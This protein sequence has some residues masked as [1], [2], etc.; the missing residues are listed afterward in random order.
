MQRIILRIAALWMVA[1]TFSA[2]NH[3][4]SAQ[5]S[6]TKTIPGDY[7]TIG[8]AIADIQSSGLSGNVIL[9]LQQSY[10]WH[11]EFYPLT[12]P[13][14]FPTGHNATVT[15]RPA[16]G[17]TGVYVGTGFLGGGP[18]PTGDVPIFNIYGSYFILDGRPGGTGTSR[19]LYIWS[20]APE[21]SAI[22]FTNNASFNTVT[23]CNLLGIND[24]LYSGSLGNKKGIV[25]FS[26]EGPF[27]VGVLGGINNNTIENCLFDG[28]IIWKP[29]NA[30]Y[31]YGN[32][33]A[34]NVGNKILNN[35]IRNFTYAG[36]NI[37]PDGQGAGWTISGNSFY[38]NSPDYTYPEYAI[39]IFHTGNVS[40]AN[41]IEGNYIGGN[42]PQAAGKWLGGPFF[43]IVCGTYDGGDSVSVRNNVIKNMEKINPDPYPS[44]CYNCDR[45]AAISITNS[46]GSNK[47]YCTGNFIG[48]GNTDY[49]ISVSAPAT[50]GDADFYG[51]LYNNCS[52]GGITQNT[53]Q[54]ISMTSAESSTF[55]GIKAY[56]INNVTIAE[57][58]I[59]QGNIISTGDVTVSPLFISDDHHEVITCEP[60]PAQPAVFDH[61]LINSITA[62]STAGDA[63]FT[64]IEING[65]LAS[66]TGNV[67]GSATQVNSINVSGQTVSVN[68]VLVTG[69]PGDVSVS[70]DIIAN[71]T[72]NGTVSTSL[73][74]VHFNGTGVVKVSGN[75]INHLTAPASKGIFIEPGNGSSTA[76]VEKNTITGVNINAGNGIEVLVPATA[77]LNLNAKENT[78][79]NWQNGFFI[80]ADAGGSLTQ[81]VQGNYV[82]GNQTGY[83]N[84]TGGTQDAT[85][86]WWGSASGPSGAGPGTGDPVGS[87]VIFSPWATLATFV[88][89]DA[90]ADQTIY[91]GYGPTSKALAPSYTVCG[92]P[93]YLWSTGATTPS[94]TVSPVVTTTYSVTVK[95]ANG[96]IATDNVI[97][98]VKDIRCGNNKVK[99]CH[100][101]T[102]TNKRQTLCIGTTDVALH[103]AHGDALG[104]CSTTA[105]R[106]IDAE[107]NTTESFTIYPNPATAR[108]Q[109]QWKA[110]ENAIASIKVLDIL[111]RILIQQNFAETKGINSR[112]LLVDKLKNGNYIFIINA[113]NKIKTARFRVQH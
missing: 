92:T 10:Y 75:Q 35:E 84:Q 67:I 45:F 11:N 86:N 109:L 55:I 4:L 41:I 24:P 39:N 89:V 104:D 9:E 108:L 81:T 63:D 20:Q 64:G 26:P 85:C 97:V 15:I 19:E 68:G 83:N 22:Q 99:I 110:D 98:T 111:G 102:R 40:G 47:V 78:V 28:A 49:G 21:G 61:N 12:I 82:T 93:T 58:I 7:T 1:S 105:A 96:H 90:G 103:L 16:A 79:T 66:N 38:S 60:S 5:V 73:N 95:D 101:D 34:P 77:T 33:D 107:I 106:E 50:G 88:S 80:T 113:G 56:V 30:I 13:E 46:Y 42:A 71:I 48:G 74:G 23:Y 112:L 51:I 70:D 91:I 76:T 59:Q 53:I 36:I 65:R 14:S 31:A 100:K 2:I 94:I 27:P 62:S 87:N 52:S 43:G 72:A 44:S 17:A 32:N 29:Y 25:T 69:T 8:A 57:N 6:G 54:K 3:R 37:S 18:M